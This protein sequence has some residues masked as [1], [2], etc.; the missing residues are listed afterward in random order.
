MGFSRQEY[1]GG[2]SFSSPGDLSNPRIEP[3][4][5]ALRADTL[6]SEPPGKTHTHTHTHKKMEVFRVCHY[7]FLAIFDVFSMKHTAQTFLITSRFHLSQ[8]EPASPSPCPQLTLLHTRPRT[9]L[10]VVWALFYLIFWPHNM[11]DISFLT[12]EWTCDP[13]SGSRCFTGTFMDM[14]VL[15]YCYNSSTS[16]W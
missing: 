3:R 9:Q 15:W 14:F 8:L 4:S 1:W 11:Q 7:C 16:R 10:M 5:L 12:G 13:W 2:L 6:P